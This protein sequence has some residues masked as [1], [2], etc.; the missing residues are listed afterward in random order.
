M[1]DGWKLM[2]SFRRA[3]LA[4]PMVLAAAAALSLAACGA[5]GNSA[6]GGNSADSFQ[7]AFDKSFNAAFDKST[8]DSCV[9]SATAHGAAPDAAER[10][11]TCIVGQLDNLTVQQKRGLSRSSP[12]L[13]LA[14]S[15]CRS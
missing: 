13:S 12:E 9:R 8:H 11:C 2:E 4:R 7:G 1:I 3:A 5:P 15:A 14:A 6:A 10:Y